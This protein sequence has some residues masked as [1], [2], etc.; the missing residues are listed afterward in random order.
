MSGTTVRF[1]GWIE[2]CTSESRLLLRHPGRAKSCTT[3]L[4]LTMATTQ[5]AT[6]FASAA[7]AAYAVYRLS[8]WK[9]LGEKL[10]DAIASSD[11]VCALLCID[12]QTWLDVRA[13]QK[14][15]SE[16]NES[17]S[18]HVR[19]GT[20]GD[21]V[22][23][24]ILETL[25]E[26]G[27]DLGDMGWIRKANEGVTRTAKEWD[28]YFARL[29]VDPLTGATERKEVV[30]VVPKFA[31]AV[32]LHMRTLLGKMEVNEANI[33]LAQRKYL[34]ICRRR[35]V[36]D[37]DTVAHQQHTMNA[38]FTEDVLDRVGLALARAPT[39]VRWLTSTRK[40]A[41]GGPTVC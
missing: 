29:G 7:I 28:A 5:R 17:I 35:G 26:D 37:V 25:V 4:T 30:R 10:G 23:Q 12:K 21:C 40:S 8:P 19:N 33:L 32:A 1:R 41:G 20:T 3:Q 11:A 14:V 22:D 2:H 15:R 6:I 13:D 36:R 38:F 9:K 34:E 18:L 24:V 16:I 39:W 31:A 27:Y